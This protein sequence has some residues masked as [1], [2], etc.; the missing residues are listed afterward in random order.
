MSDIIQVR[1]DVAANWTAVNPT[2]AEGEIGY[3]TD[4]GYLKFGNGTSL[5]SALSYNSTPAS[6]IVDGTNKVI[7]NGTTWEF[8]INN[9]RIAILDASGNLRLKGIIITEDSTV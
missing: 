7:L 1:R 4:T 9:V 8:W 6:S 2:L 3:E 5:W